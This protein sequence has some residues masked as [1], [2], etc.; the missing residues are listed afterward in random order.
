[1]TP[2]PG[3]LASTAGV[4]A[5]R[6]DAARY[7]ASWDS[8]IGAEKVGGRWNPKG[9]K[10]VYCSFDPSTCI[11]ESAVHR[12]FEVLDVQSHVLTS[13]NVTEPTA[14]RVVQ[15]DEIP[16]PAWRHGGPPSAGQQT[17][18]ADLLSRHA[19]VA[20][21]SAVSKLSWNLAFEPSIANGKYVLRSQDRLVLDT[22]LNPSTR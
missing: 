17:F 16:N 2:L 1:M 22:R 18:G 4:V 6:L 13:F 3:L 11:I 20:F 21:P 14:V 5:W 10:A 9:F 12:G 7:A 8:G 15:P 19:F